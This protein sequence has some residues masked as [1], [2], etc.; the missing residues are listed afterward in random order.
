MDLPPF[1]LMWANLPQWFHA[2][3]VPPKKPSDPPKKAFPQIP[4]VAI[5]KDWETC[6]IQMSQAL[7]R[8]GHRV[9]YV[10]KERVLRD[11]AGTEY[12]L[13]VA[14]MRGYLTTAFFEPEKIAR[15]DDKKGL[16]P[17]WAVQT[18]IVDRKGIIAF[19]GRHIDLWDGRK[20]HGE[21]YIAEALW[22]ADSA[23]TDGLFFWEAKAAPKP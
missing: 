9:N 6:C 2:K 3:P 5:P 8:A 20:I 4:G 10:K 23:V 12:M 19:G 15:R 21:H 11:A 17:R 13:D 14:E 18:Q 16:I 1:D 7:N 22:E